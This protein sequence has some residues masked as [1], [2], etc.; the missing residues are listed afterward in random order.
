MFHDKGL[1]GDI[2]RITNSLSTSQFSEMIKNIPDQRVGVLHG[3]NQQSGRLGLG[4]SNFM[5]TK[6]AHEHFDLIIP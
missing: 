2:D 6:H 3:H 5:Q 1:V 4:L